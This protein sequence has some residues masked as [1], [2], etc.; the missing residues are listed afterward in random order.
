[1]ADTLASRYQEISNASQKACLI[2]VSKLQPTD[3]LA[4]LYDLGHR[5]FG[6]NYAQELNEKATALAAR[7]MK[8]IRWHF[9]GH[10]QTNKVKT[11]IPWVS[12]VHSVDSFKL[13]AELSKRWAPLNKPHPLPVFIEINLAGEAAKA[14]VAAQDARALCLSVARECPSLQLEGLMCIPP[15]GED[16]RV[17]FAKLRK[18]EATCWPFTRG[19]LSMGMSSDFPVA[20]EEGATHVRVGTRLFGARPGA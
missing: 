8:G 14:G 6:E 2:A 16:S 7:G 3:A 10:L 17:S 9:I 1:M 4:E 19:G 18:L 20:L 5:D 11:I 15:A 12:A 13:A